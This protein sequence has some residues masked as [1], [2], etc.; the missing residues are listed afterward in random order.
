M[1]NKPTKWGVKVF[2]FSDATNGYV[3]RL[4]IY[5]GKQL[6]TTVDAGLCLRVVL[7][8]MTGLE[9]KGLQLYTD[10]YYS[11]PELFLKLYNEMG[12]NSCGTVQT[13]RIGFPKSIVKK[14]KE[15]R[16]YYD[17]RSNGALLSCAW[18]DRRFVY[19]LSTL[20]CGES[21]SGMTTMSRKNADGSRSQ[22]ECP[23]LLPDYQKN[24]KG[25]NGGDQMIGCFK[26]GRRSR[27]WWKRVFSYTI[28]LAILNA[29]ILDSHMNQPEH[30]QK[31]RKNGII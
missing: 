20:H 22:V 8:L 16:G 15:D 25:V 1:E 24:M 9:Y 29:Y 4:Q 28:Q 27:K 21:A 7:E 11:S 23:P 12:I 2:V 6:D 18:Y 30:S 3:Y 13:N 19:F 14:K 10:N 31:G 5:T 26:I 17:Y